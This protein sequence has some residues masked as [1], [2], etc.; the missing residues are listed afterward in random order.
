ML[1]DSL[2]YRDELE[3]ILKDKVKLINPKL[4]TIEFTDYN[5]QWPT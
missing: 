1:V 2:I 5:H 3:A 4:S